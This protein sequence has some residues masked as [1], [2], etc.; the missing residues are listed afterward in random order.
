VSED[1]QISLKLQCKGWF[2]RWAT[3]S[4]AEFQ[5]GVS[6]TCGDELSRWQKYA[7]GCSEIFFNPV[8]YWFTRGPLTK[9]FRQFLWS[10][11]PVHFKWSILAYM[12]SYYAFALACPITVLNFIFIGIYDKADSFCESF[13][14]RIV[15]LICRRLELESIL[16]LPLALYRSGER[17]G[18]RFTLS[19][20]RRAC[21]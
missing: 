12:A 17:C 5:E 7:F 13:E 18:L 9:L 16:H 20:T 11:I 8:R 10:P 2:L 1:F 6:L 21:R 4:N 3:Y 14:E 19:S 15:Y